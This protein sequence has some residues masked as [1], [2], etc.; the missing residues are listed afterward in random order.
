MLV[1]VKMFTINCDNCG[2]SLSES[3][4]YSCWNDENSVEEIRQEEGWEKIDN[5][6]YCTECFR[7]DEDYNVEILQILKNK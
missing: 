6:H 2:C 3:S 4:E 5:K 1:E 7:Y